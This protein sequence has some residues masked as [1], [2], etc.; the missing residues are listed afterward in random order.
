MA[1]AAAGVHA[2]PAALRQVALKHLRNVV[3]DHSVMAD[4]LE[5]RA[6]AHP[7]AHRAQG[8]PGLELH[9]DPQEHEL[10]SEENPFGFPGGLDGPDS[11]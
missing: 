3:A 10:L 4:I 6:E 1:Y 7:R 8:W 9:Q 11:D 2:V 5:V